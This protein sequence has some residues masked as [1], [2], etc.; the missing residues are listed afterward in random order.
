MAFQPAS[1]AGSV[2]SSVHAG[3]PLCP[4]NLDQSELSNY[5]RKFMHAI[6]TRVSEQVA[7]HGAQNIFERKIKSAV[8]STADEDS[9]G[10]H[11]SVITSLDNFYCECRSS[12]LLRVCRLL[13]ARHIELY[14]LCLLHRQKT[15]HFLLE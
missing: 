10:F 14:F 4:D 5:A 1:P 15:S 13:C 6:A 7:R 11:A 12:A 3:E 9:A 8:P 2:T